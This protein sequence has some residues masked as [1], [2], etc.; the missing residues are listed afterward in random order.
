MNKYSDISNRSYYIGQHVNSRTSPKP[1][2][3]LRESLS[4]K[5]ITFNR[6]HSESPEVSLALRSPTNL[7]PPLGI[8]N[9]SYETNQRYCDLS[10]FTTSVK[11]VLKLPEII[12]RHS[13]FSTILD[14]I[15]KVLSPKTRLIHHYLK[16]NESQKFTQASNE[17]NYYRITCKG[18][19]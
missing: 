11:S 9:F 13:D 14:N 4:L 16:E 2:Q 12:P 3:S 19:K 5:E 8:S 7:Q 1:L 6:Y 15:E 17:F 10:E 18:K